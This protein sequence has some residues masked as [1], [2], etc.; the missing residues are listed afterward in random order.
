MSTENLI[1]VVGSLA[2]L[3]TTVAFIPQVLKIWKQGG[4]DLSYG[5]L[6]LYLTGVLLWLVYG[7]LVRA[8][9]IIVANSASGI[10]ITL[11]TILKAWT[12]KRDAGK[13]LR[14]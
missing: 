3:C 1:G 14:T 7:I 4:R 5:M 10:L 13:I 12:A 9:E 6:T 11:A 2:G 8:H